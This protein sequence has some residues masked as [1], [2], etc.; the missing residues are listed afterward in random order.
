MKFICQYLIQTFEAVKIAADNINYLRD[1]LDIPF[2]FET[3]VNYLQPLPGEMTDGSF[4]AAVAETAER[5]IVLALHN[6]W[7]NEKNGSR[8]RHTP[9]YLNEPNILV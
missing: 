8:A 1:R 3:G 6:L 4:F 7:C 2:A 9:P 5:G